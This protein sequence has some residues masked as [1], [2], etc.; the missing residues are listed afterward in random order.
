VFGIDPIKRNVALCAL[1][2]RTIRHQA[3]VAGRAASAAEFDS[4][5]LDDTEGEKRQTAVL[6]QRNAPFGGGLAQGVE[7][8]LRQR[9]RAKHRV[10][11]QFASLDPIVLGFQGRSLLF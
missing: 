1:E 10:K 7:I 4:S 2:Q 5:L 3:C 9:E 8:L 6:S 11:Y